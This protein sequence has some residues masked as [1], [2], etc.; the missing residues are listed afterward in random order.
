MYVGI[1]KDKY[2]LF[3]FYLNMDTIETSNSNIVQGDV[4]HTQN[5]FCKGILFCPISNCFQNTDY[6]RSF[7]E[8]PNKQCNRTQKPRL[9]TVRT[10]LQE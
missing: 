9:M 10:I 1:P 3:T 6:G 4:S 5:S 8:H 2:I 7:P